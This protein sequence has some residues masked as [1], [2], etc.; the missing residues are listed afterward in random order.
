VQ[1]PRS[2]VVGEL[3]THALRLR[4]LTGPAR[5]VA[6]DRRLGERSGM[7]PERLGLGSRVRDKGIPVRQ[8][9]PKRRPSAQI[10][11]SAHRRRPRFALMLRA[12]R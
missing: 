2:G 4:H 7:T 8:L 10:G 11:R 12:I 9:Q 6:R 3:D 5:A 1:D